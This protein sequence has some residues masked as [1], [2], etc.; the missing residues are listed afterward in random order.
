MINVTPGFWINPRYIAR[1]LVEKRAEDMNLITIWFSDGTEC[2][3]HVSSDRSLKIM[4][5]IQDAL[6]GQS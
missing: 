1:M 6:S 4:G 2:E 5:Q 3:Y